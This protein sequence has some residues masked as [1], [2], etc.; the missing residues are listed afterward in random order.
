MEK[1][2]L[3]MDFENVFTELFFLQRHS[4]SALVTLCHS[5]QMITAT[6]ALLL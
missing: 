1:R 4:S 5:L 3:D 2:T 6:L